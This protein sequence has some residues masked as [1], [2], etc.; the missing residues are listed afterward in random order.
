MKLAELFEDVT[1]D[2]AFEQWF[3]GSKIVDQ[4]GKPLKLY[5]GL[6]GPNLK[7]VDFTMPRKGYSMFFSTSP[8]VAA[9]YSNP[10]DLSPDVS[11]AI[12]PVYVKATML[13]EYPTKMISGRKTFDK[14]GFDKIAARLAAGDGVV[15]RGV[16]DIGPNANSKADPSMLYSYASDIYAFGAGTP[17]VSAYAA[18][19]LI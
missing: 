4:S 12:Y 19:D 3:A 6:R 15:V 17:I 7:D 2:P 14:F 18:K 9:S 8:Y 1:T 11:G 13:K 16:V 5:R 10:D